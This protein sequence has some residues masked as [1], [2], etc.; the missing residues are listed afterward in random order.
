MDAAPEI[1]VEGIESA[2]DLIDPVFLDSP[3]FRSDALS[4][5]LEAEVIVKLECVNPIRSFKAR[6]AFAF[7]ERHRETAPT[8]WLCAS[9]GNFG[10]GLAYAATR[11]SIP[12]I[13]YAATTANAYKV[14][15]MRELGAE[16]TLV[17]D[18]FDAAKDACRAHAQR[19]GLTFVE[20]GHD[21]AITEGAGTIATELGSWRPPLDEVILPV[22]NGA[23]V[24]GVGTWLKARC[25]ETR[26][27][28]AGALGAPAMERSYRT[29]RV[30]TTDSVSTIADGVATRI[31]VPSAV[32]TMLEVVDDMIL[33]D[34]TWI[35]RAMDL[36]Q[37]ELGITPEPAGAVP[38]AAAMR[39]PGRVKGRR[40]ALLV[41]GS[42]V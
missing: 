9:A 10:Q 42:N 2:R 39:E 23:L 14:A 30:E 17:G 15:K 35:R 41:S 21:E 4:R 5:L 18:D 25:P 29:G 26:I 8:P 38:L 16:V 19:D 33:V 20:D 40:V 7:V 22:G 1:S 13:V 6:G 11:H 31:P 37:L 12:L 34:E 27:V 36:I 3:Q 24:N 28:G 32:A